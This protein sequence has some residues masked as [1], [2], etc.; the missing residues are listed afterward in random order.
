MTKIICRTPLGEIWLWGE[1]SRFE[2]RDPVVLAISGLYGGPETLWFRM[3]DRLPEAAVFAAQLPGHLSPELSETSLSAFA[4]AFD[5]AIA[6]A[7]EGRPVLVCGESVGGTVALTLTTPQIGVLA[8]DPPLNSQ[9]MRP[10]R[11]W[12]T[13]IWRDRPDQRTLLQNL[14]GFEGEDFRPLDYV[15][16]L[17]RAARI[18]AGGL[19]KA[20]IED[21]RPFIPSVIEPETRQALGDLPFIRLS[22]VIDAGHVVS[23]YEALVLD[24]VREELALTVALYRAA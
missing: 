2:S 4:Q 9:G 14:F 20:E 7:F 22:T 11:T 16:E 24:V 17:K 12:F 19:F 10:F 21:E 5:F 13:E 23:W 1:R 8:F 6:S 15:P 18:V 3:Q